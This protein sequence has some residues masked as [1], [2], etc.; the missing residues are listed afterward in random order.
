MEVIIIVTQN[1]DEQIEYAY[2]KINEGKTLFDA[3]DETI[4]IV[5]NY[6]K[7]IGE[8]I[9]NPDYVDVFMF[10]TFWLALNIGKLIGMVTGNLYVGLSED[11]IKKH[12]TF[13]K[14]DP[15]SAHCN[16]Y[17]WMLDLLRQNGYNKQQIE[18]FEDVLDHIGIIIFNR[19]QRKYNCERIWTATK[20]ILYGQI[21]YR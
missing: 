20:D 12:D 5:R 7:S 14:K 21:I 16:W 15:L 10:Q 1:I 2:S 13:M 8:H 6:F 19:F 4:S 9:F 3:E 18:R 17:Y 11:I